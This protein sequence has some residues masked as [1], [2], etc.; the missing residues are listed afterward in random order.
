MKLER[1]DI[2]T[3]LAMTAAS[4]LVLVVAYVLS[5]QPAHS[6]HSSFNYYWS[7]GGNLNTV[8]S[9]VIYDN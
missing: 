8:S 2:L 6:Y 3:V 9:N 1:S 4:M 5:L 7:S